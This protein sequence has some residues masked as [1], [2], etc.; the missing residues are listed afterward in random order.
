MNLIIQYLIDAVSAGGIY[1]LAALGIGLMFGIMG[2]INFAH[3]DFF[4]IGAYVIF[5][6]SGRPALIVVATTLIAVIL[7]A[8]SSDRFVFRPL[9]G[10]GGPMLLIASFGLA[11]LLENIMLM[12]FGGRSK[13]VGFGYSLAQTITIGSLRISL[14]DI[15]TIAVTA[16]LLIA[17]T[18]FLRKTRYGIE[19]RA[20]ASDFRMARL[21]GIRANRVVAMAFAVSGLLAAAVSILLVLQRGSVSP[22]MGVMLILFAFLATIM[23]GMGSLPGSVVGGFILGFGGVILEIVLPLDLRPY[24]DAFLF[25]MVIVILILFPSGLIPGRQGGKRV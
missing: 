19:M 13:A 25:S 18:L 7:L 2:L 4:M 6:M 17:L 3:G 12:L 15:V 20:A 1:A 22:N 8:L 11:Y 9:R 14:V 16:V 23:G 24:R 21:L 10:A 5:L